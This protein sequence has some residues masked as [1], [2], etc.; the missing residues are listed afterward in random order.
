MTFKSSVFMIVFAITLFSVYLAYIFFT[1]MILKKNLLHIILYNVDISSKV[2]H[3]FSWSY[4][5]VF[6]HEP[7]FS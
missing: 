6:L 7:S 3:G 4:L 5:F 2:G 1:C